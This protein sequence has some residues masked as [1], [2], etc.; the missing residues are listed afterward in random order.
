ML[1]K[2]QAK[3][4]LSIILKMRQAVLDADAL[5][6]SVVKK[7]YKNDTDDMQ[8]AFWQNFQYMTDYVRN[9]V[10]VDA[11]EDVVSVCD[12]CIKS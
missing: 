11:T 2:T 4:V 6:D 9:Y 7:D 3:K 12:E 8:T 1:T 5:T 10:D